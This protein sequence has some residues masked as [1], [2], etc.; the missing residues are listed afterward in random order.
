MQGRLERSARDLASGMG[1]ACLVLLETVLK[2][3]LHHQTARLAQ[4]DLMP[5]AAKR[6]VHVPH[7]LRRRVAPTKFEQLLP[8]MTSIAMDHSLWDTTKQFVNHG[9]LVLLRYTIK[10]LLNDVATEC[11]HAER[12]GISSDSLG[13]GNY[14]VR[15]AVFEAALDQEVAKTVYHQ[16]VRLGDDCLDNLVLLLRRADLEL[17]LQENGSLLVVTAD[18]LVDDVLPVAA[19]IAV[20]KATVVHRLSGSHILGDTGLAGSLHNL[21]AE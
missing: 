4:R 14:L 8:D 15:R 12:E 17:L 7:N 9:G 6:F 10:R 5:H 21:S 2:D 20:K 11:I 1:T 13:N 3:V 16:R 18:D 19:H